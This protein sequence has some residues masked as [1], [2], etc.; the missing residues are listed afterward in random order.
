MHQAVGKRV[1]SSDFCHAAVG[2]ES[3]VPRL[4]HSV[5]GIVTGTEFLRH[6]KGVD[7]LAVQLGAL[8]CWQFDCDAGRFKLGT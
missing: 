4:G 1:W 6:E 2:F 3:L 5:A 8:S 7:S